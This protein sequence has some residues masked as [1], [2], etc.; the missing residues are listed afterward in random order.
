MLGSGLEVETGNKWPWRYFGDYSRLEDLV[1]DP[2]GRP[3]AGSR[4]GKK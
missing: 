4:I 2:E 1:N 3:K